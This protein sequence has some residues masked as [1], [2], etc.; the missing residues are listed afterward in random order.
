MGRNLLRY[1]HAPA[2][3]LLLVLSLQA[4]LATANSEGT[5]PEPFHAEYKV[6]VL[7]ARG[8]ATLELR[9][10]AGDDYRFSTSLRA[11]GIWRALVRGGL[12][13][14][15]H[16]D[17]HGSRPQT[18]RYSLVNEFGS[19]PRNGDYEFVWDAG[20]VRGIYKD[21]PLELPI[22]REV[23]DRSLFPIR[24]M[25]DLAQGNRLSTYTVLDRDEIVTIEVGY[26]DRKLVTVPF[27]RFE[28]MQVRHRHSVDG[29]QTFLWCAPELDYLPVRLEQ[30][31]DGKRFMVADLVS[32]GSPPAEPATNGP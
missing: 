9:R 30:L 8:R 1:C 21:Q 7:I 16:F 31:R 24:L 15:S 18:L 2:A 29:E 6:K 13:E 14:V 5:L 19:R 32:Y 4:T 3:A 27:G 25:T 28:A 26:G 17:A 22:T 12:E 11:T 23:M 10:D 20:I